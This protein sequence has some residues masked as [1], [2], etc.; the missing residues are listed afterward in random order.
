MLEGRGVLLCPFSTPFQPPVFGAQTA[1]GMGCWPARWVCSPRDNPQKHFLTWPAS[2]RRSAEAGSRPSADYILSPKVG[3]SFPQSP[4]RS[5][6]E[7][8]A[9]PGGPQ[10]CCK[11]AGGEHRDKTPNSIKYQGSQKSLVPGEMHKGEIL[12]ISQ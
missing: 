9:F 11:G 6:G 3:L 12:M 10:W 4:R 1:L 7:C 8:P 5:S 2:P